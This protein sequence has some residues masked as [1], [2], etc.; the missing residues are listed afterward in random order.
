MRNTK[1]EIRMTG[2]FVL[3][4]ACF[5]GGQQG[6][7]VHRRRQYTGSLNQCQ[8]FKGTTGGANTSSDTAV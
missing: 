4:L 6:F 3:S 5:D 2:I 1:D 7:L 8:G